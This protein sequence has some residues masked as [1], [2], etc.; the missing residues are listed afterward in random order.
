MEKRIKIFQIF[1]SKRGAVLQEEINN[2][3]IAY[4]HEAITPQEYDLWCRFYYP[5]VT[6]TPCF[7]NGIVLEGR[8]LSW[9]ARRLRAQRQ[10][11]VLS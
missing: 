10:R 8:G 3:L 4:G 2:A 7:Y 1:Q 11:K 5:A 9:L 6:D